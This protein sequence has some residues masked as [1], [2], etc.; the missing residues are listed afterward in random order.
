MHQ[1]YEITCTSLLKESRF[2]GVQVTISVRKPN[3]DHMKR[4]KD[5]KIVYTTLIMKI[6][7]VG[8]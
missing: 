1:P 7:G 8:E 5:Q 6:D 2:K 4:N 3:T